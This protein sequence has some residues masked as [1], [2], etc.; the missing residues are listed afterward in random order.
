MFNLKNYCNE[1]ISWLI[2]RKKKVKAH[3]LSDWSLENP[4]VRDEGES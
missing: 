4:I 2:V 3:L 1:A